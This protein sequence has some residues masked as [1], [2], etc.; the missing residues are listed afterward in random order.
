VNQ[1]EALDNWEP[2]PQ[3]Y[4]N[5][6]MAGTVAFPRGLAWRE[7][8]VDK[9]FETWDDL[10]DSSLEG[11]VGFEPWNNAGS[12]YFYVINKIKG[13]SV[14]NIEPGLK[15]LRNF[16]QATDPIVFD[17]IDQAMKLFQNGDM[18]AAPFLSARAENLELDEGLEMGWAVPKG[19]APMDYWGYPITKHNDEDRHE[20][21]RVFAEG[22]L[23]PKTQATFAEDFGYP[24]CHPEAQKEISEEAKENH[25]MMNPSEEQL[26]RY[27][28]DINWVKAAELSAQHGE[29]F[30]K[31]IAGG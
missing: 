31:V 3:A 22:C 2:I 10:A 5:E 23:T 20:Q 11:K 13:G 8:L 6:Y 18:V 26:Q 28:M 12:K 7:D 9:Q 24:P 19:G 25:P 17:S 30:R 21:A 14:D 16:V 15:W 29:R 4:K 27:N 1:K